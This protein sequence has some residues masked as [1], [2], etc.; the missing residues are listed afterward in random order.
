MA[1]R[2]DIVAASLFLFALPAN[3]LTV[4]TVSC[5]AALGRP[6]LLRAMPVRAC[7]PAEPVDKQLSDPKLITYDDVGTDFRPLINVALARLDKFRSL[8]GKPKYETIDGMIDAYVQESADAGLNWTRAEAESEVLRY[9]QRQALADEGGIDD[10]GQDKAAFALLAGLI[11]LVS[12]SLAQNAGL[13]EAPQ[14]SFQLP[15]M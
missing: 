5:T 15:P 14:Q 1:V 12:A 11:G 6:S 4:T 8:S 2:V 9:L 10:D 3:A 7:Q 13:I